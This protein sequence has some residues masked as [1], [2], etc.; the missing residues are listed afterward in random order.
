MTRI[1]KHLLVKA[2]FEVDEV[3]RSFGVLNLLASLRP[4]V[5]VMDMNMPGLRGDDVL[6]LIRDDPGLRHTQVLFYSGI[7]EW[8]LQEISERAGANAWV[9]KT[10]GPAALIARVRELARRETV[11]A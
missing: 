6:A 1:T 4:D 9:H 3:N 10:A 5:L 11:V 7:E 2:G 8:R